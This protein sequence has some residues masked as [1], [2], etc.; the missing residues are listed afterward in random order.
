VVTYLASDDASYVSGQVITINGGGSRV[1][2][3]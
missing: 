2:P 3:W 1:M